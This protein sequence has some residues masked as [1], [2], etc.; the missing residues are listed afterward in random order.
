MQNDRQVGGQHYKNRSIQPWDFVLANQIPYM[1]GTIIKYL[2]RWRDK[3]GLN[4]LRK[5]QHFL[6]K[7]IEW[8]MQNYEIVEED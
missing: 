6:D 4:D 3:G 8:E 7:L 2:F 5:A 1:E